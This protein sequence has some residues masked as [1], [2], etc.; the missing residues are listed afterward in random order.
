[1]NSKITTNK[2]EKS[3]NALISAAVGWVSFLVNRKASARRTTA[4]G[5]SNVKICVVNF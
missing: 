2:D 1:M 5:T 4:I 3:N